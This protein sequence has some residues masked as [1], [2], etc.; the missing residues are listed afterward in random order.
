MHLSGKNLRIW[1]VNRIL[2]HCNK[3]VKG[4]NQVIGR[5]DQPI[6][7]EK[8]FQCLRL[9]EG[10]ISYFFVVFRFYFINA[11]Q[12]DD[13]SNYRVYVLGYKSQVLTLLT[14]TS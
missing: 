1:L 14:I 2:A 4:E 9:G 6:N 8:P 12:G 3:P 13:D 11:L 5:C 7:I 10:N